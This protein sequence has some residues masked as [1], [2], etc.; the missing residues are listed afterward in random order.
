MKLTK[1]ALANI[2]KGRVGAQ[3]SI[4]S[5]PAVMFRNIKSDTTNFQ[6]TYK[7]FHLL[8]SC[9]FKH[10]KIK[11]KNQLTVKAMLNLDRNCSCPYYINNKKT[12][13]LFFSEKPAVML[14]LLD[15]DLENFA[16]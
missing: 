10:Y 1:L 5:L 9:D 6:L 7:G 15:G 8:K 12:Y 3:D 2:V 11:I 14:Q 13:V 4:R 16:V